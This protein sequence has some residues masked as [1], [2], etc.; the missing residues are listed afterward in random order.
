MF[1]ASHRDGQSLGVR[2][3]ESFAGMGGPVERSSRID[4]RSHRVE[5]RPPQINRIAR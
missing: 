5:Q 2:V 4:S 3:S 1:P